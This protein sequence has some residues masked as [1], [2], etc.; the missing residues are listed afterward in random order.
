MI[1]FSCK[2]YDEIVY[3]LKYKYH[4]HLLNPVEACDMA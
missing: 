4:T 3:D 2:M 1:A